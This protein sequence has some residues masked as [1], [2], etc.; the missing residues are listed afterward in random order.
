MRRDEV[1]VVDESRCIGCTRC[2]DAC[3]ADAHVDF[4]LEAA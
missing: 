3:P 4:V 1:A 2:I